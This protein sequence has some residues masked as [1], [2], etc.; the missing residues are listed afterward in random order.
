MYSYT[1]KTIWFAHAGHG[2]PTWASTILHYFVEPQ[3][4]WPIWLAIVAVAGLLAA[5]RASRSR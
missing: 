5:R 2:D 1:I 3:H 4:A